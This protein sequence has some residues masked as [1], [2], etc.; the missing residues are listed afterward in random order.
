MIFLL[1]H[2]MGLSLG[3]KAPTKETSMKRKTGACPDFSFGL[4]IFVSFRDK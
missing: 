2:K 4:S 3:K 1:Y